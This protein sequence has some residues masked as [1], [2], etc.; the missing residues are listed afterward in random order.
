MTTSVVLATNNAK[1]LAELRRIVVEEGLDIEVLGLGDVATFPEPAETEWTFEGNALIKARAAAQHTGLVALA[2]DSGI[3][4][5]ALNQMPGVRS[6]RWAGPQH[7]DLANLDLLLAQ[8]SDVRDPHR[9]ARFVAAMALVTPDGREF[10]SRGEMPGR[11]T[12]A[13][14]GEGGFGYDPI[15]V[16]D[17]GEADLTTAQMTPEAKDTISHRGKAVRAIIGTLA[18]VIGGEA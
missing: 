2:D 4:V 7:D 5:D 15:F 3:C 6:A 12:G 17:D 1:K 9:T 16:P 14:R 18:S 11:I 8:I 13:P 10:T